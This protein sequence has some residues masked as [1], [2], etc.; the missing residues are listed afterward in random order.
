MAETRPTHLS[1]SELPISDQHFELYGRFWDVAS[2][3]IFSL[4]AVA[5]LIA[6]ANELT[7]REWTVATLSIGQGLLYF[8]CITRG[9]WPISRRNLI[10]YFVGGVC[11]WGLACWLDP[12]TWWLGFT[13]FGQM[14]GL[15]PL[16]AVIPGTAIV[17][18]LIALITSDWNLRQI[19]LGAVIGFTFQWLTGIALYLFIYNIIRTSRERAKLITKLESAQKELEIAH[20]RDTE[21]ATL[22]ERERLAR[23]L[24]DSLGHALVALSVQLEAIQRLY[25][26]DPERAS[27]QVDE[28]K[29]LTRT[30]MDDLRRSLAG[31]RTPGLGERRL[32]DALQ[33]LSVDAGQRAH[34]AIACHI[35]DD[36]NQ[37]SP[38]HAET[39]WRVAQEALANIER[40]AAAHSVQLQL[41]ITSN[42]ALLSIQDDGRGL[43]PDA[44]KQPGHYG[45][46]GMRER[47]EGLGGTLTLTGNSN[48]SRVDVKL[49]IL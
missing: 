45:L 4:A 30:S 16:Q 36:A 10:L 13:Y 37:L 17:T 23:D 3:L 35:H 42:A 7:W 8:F 1:N 40:H 43:P 32:S 12:F 28:L 38:A 2:L 26:V 14:F 46:R 34:L 24:H 27:A 44:E 9:G 47:V 21:L 41:N 19:P 18:F 25:K 39:L 5:V 31:L 15:L 29:T 20:Q 22:Q 33:A 48:G 11:M 6:N 49:P